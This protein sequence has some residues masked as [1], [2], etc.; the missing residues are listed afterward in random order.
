MAF[1]FQ[2]FV[3]QDMPGKSFYVAGIG[4]SAGGLQAI[5]EFFLNIPPEPGIAF[6]IVTHL[7]REHRS[8]LDRIISGC[9]SMKVQRMKGADVIE[10]NNIYVMPEGAK[11][12]IKNGCLY[13]KDRREEEIINRTVDEFFFSLAEDCRDHSIGIVFSGMGSDGAEGVKRIHESGGIVMVQ[14]PST[15][16]YK[17]M[18]ENA[19]RRDHPDQILPPAM[20]AQTILSE[21]ARKEVE[22]KTLS[23]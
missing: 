21:I 17:S 20:L 5:R 9:T 3:K 2:S 16:A 14:D 12:Y 6:C 15:T 11:A 13:L 10:P 4:A 8:I 18:P 7:L 22:M 19:I 1:E 23:S